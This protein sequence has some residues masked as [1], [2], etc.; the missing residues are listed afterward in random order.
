MLEAGIYETKKKS[1][2]KLKKMLTPL[3]KPVLD[4]VSAFLF[5]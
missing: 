1:N 3:V 5:P 2:P 4:I